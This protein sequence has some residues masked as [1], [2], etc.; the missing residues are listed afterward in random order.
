MKKSKLLLFSG[1]SAI[2]S[3]FFG[4][5][6]WFANRQR[7]SRVRYELAEYFGDTSKE[8]FL[9]LL[10]HLLGAACI[11]CFVLAIEFLI[12]GLIEKKK[13]G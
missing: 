7:P 12:I 1:I 10:P 8:D 3:V 6:A 5:G 9:L 13:R 4:I 11:V 2:F